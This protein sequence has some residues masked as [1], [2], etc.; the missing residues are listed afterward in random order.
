MCKWKFILCISLF[1]SACAIEKERLYESSAEQFRVDLVHVKE[2]SDKLQKNSHFKNKIKD[3]ELTKY[4]NNL[5]VNLAADNDILLALD[6]NVFL[7]DDVGEK[8]L[9]NAAF[10][11]GHLYLSNT[12]LSKLSYEN[13]VA[14]FI[15]IQFGHILNRSFV[16]KASFEDEQTTDSDQMIN[17][18]F[19][20]T[21][22]QMQA[23]IDE[24]ILILY[25]KG[26]DPR[27]IGGF[28]KEYLVQNDKVKYPKEVIQNWINYT[29]L[30]IATYPPLINPVI[31]TKEFTDIKKKLKNYKGKNLG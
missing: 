12:I 8:N 30:R 19:H 29:Y 22:D 20:Y 28:F 21:E 2:I 4:V 13:E 17:N 6:V 16:R 7:V 1:L 14:A 24:A 11:D 26:Y 23:T 5:A 9:Y 25:Q 27:G 18:Y 10:P 3:K 15:A 31:T